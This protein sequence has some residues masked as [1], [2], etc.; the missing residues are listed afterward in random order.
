MPGLALETVEL[1]VRERV[2]WITLNRPD[3][4]N[5]W[6]PQLGLDLRAAL[7]HVAD[8]EDVRVVVIT[9]AGRA[10]SA[11]ADLRAGL[12]LDHGT[13]DVLTLLREN[14]NVLIMRIR[15]LRKPVMAVVNGAA[16]G[17]ACSLVAAADLVIAAESARFLLAFKNIGLTLDGG[18]SALLVGRVGHSR[19][20]EMALLAEP[21]SASQALQWGLINRVVAD[22]QLLSVAAQTA[23]SLA[24]G[25]PGAHAA[26]KQSLNQAAYPRL[27][28]I[29]DLEAV[30]QQERFASADAAEGISAFLQKRPPQF[31]GR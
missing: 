20:S 2:A 5:A 31:T 12:G 6:T 27:A 23:A 11:G 28:Q 26:I 10:F 18:A 29:L 1:A 14:Y 9:G 21:V 25:A 19:A 30:L 24:A 13:P 4:L 7:D 16:V 3:A 8:D 17:I 22:D 15:E